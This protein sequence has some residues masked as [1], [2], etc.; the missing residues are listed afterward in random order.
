MAHSQKPEIKGIYMSNALPDGRVWGPDA[1]QGS[2]TI[3]EEVITTNSPP[4]YLVFK[5]ECPK[6][7]QQNCV[8][9][10][11]RGDIH[12]PK[13]GQTI[14][15]RYNDLGI[16]SKIKLIDG[17]TNKGINEFDF[18]PEFVASLPSNN[19]NDNNDTPA[20]PSFP[21]NDDDDAQAIPSN[22]ESNDNSQ[23]S[24]SLRR[25]RGL[26]RKIVKITLRV[27]LA[28]ALILLLLCCFRPGDRKKSLDKPDEQAEIQ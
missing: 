17:L 9:S 26:R 11:D 7:I 20:T 6:P 13:N 27:M 21:S 3:W 23:T 16:E 4:A 22:N 1:N 24:T 8:P 12:N 5:P 25:G 15:N 28:L 19:N 14:V 2:S 10:P 18:F